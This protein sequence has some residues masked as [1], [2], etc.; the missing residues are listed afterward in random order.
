MGEKNKT[1]AKSKSGNFDSNRI[2][3]ALAAISLFL[4]NVLLSKYGYNIDNWWVVASG[5]EILSS[6]IPH[7]N[8]FSAGQSTP[9]VIQQWLYCVIFTLAYDAGGWQGVAVLHGVLSVFATTAMC[10][11]VYPWCGRK[12]L[13]KMFGIVF[14]CSLSYTNFF[15]RPWCLSFV[16]FSLIIGLMERYRR[17]PQKIQMI[18]VPLLVCL[19]VNFHAALAP[20]DLGIVAAYLVPL[21]K[22]PPWIQRA[23]YP[24][25]PL[26]GL[27]L[28]CVLALMLNPY[29]IDGPMYTLNSLGTVNYKHGIIEMESAAMWGSN[30]F[31]PMAC[32]IVTLFSAI[33]VASCIRK[34][35]VDI[36]VTLLWIAAVVSVFVAVRNMMIVSVALLPLLAS[37]MEVPDGRHG[38][39]RRLVK[40]SAVSAA[41]AL[42]A[43]WASFVICNI[44]FIQDNPT[45]DRKIEST[46]DSRP[47]KGGIGEVETGSCQVEA[48]NALENAGAEA[49]DG[50]I[51][52]FDTGGYAEYRGF[53]VTLD[54]RPELW[55]PNNITRSSSMTSYIDYIDVSFEK[56]ED[57]AIALAREKI[58]DVY[59]PRC[60][61]A[62]VSNSD[63]NL[64]KALA[65]SPDWELVEETAFSSAWRNLSFG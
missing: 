26:I 18:L 38:E 55:G 31:A 30:A 23:G 39:Y 13:L 7:A 28:L 9:I 45:S 1:L 49:G 52:T 48:A 24:R 42:V 20:L 37:A 33:Y 64:E 25:L 21:P 19:H 16:F 51:T 22:F 65:E 56:D 15:W 3:T 61:W 8:P 2:L 50:I 41:L 60:K 63:S 40:V 44:V 35:V 46:E 14:I 54:S 12:H 47:K 59:K 27:F 36:P 17:N 11:A 5:H 43:G 34:H 10:Y 57:K 58:L 53:K 4:V 62:L 29:G 6:G 32:V